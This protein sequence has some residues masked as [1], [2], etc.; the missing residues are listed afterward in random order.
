MYPP[1]IVVMPGLDFWEAGKTDGWG[2]EEES[3][4]GPGRYL[5]SRK[6]RQTRAALELHG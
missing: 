6:E 5:R 3:R 1:A 2:L 4:E